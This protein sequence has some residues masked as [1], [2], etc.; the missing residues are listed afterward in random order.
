MHKLECLVCDKQ[1]ESKWQRTKTCSLECHRTRIRKIEGRF[2][3]EYIPNGSVGALAELVVS[4]DLL[5]K[6][7]SVFRALSPSCFCDLIAVKGNKSLKIEVR[8]GYLHSITKRLN[9]PTK[10][11]EQTDC[12][13]VFERNSKEIFY[14]TKDKNE[15]KL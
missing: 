5:S 8:T 9:F 12:F 14:L 10:T 7:F 4:A 15:F 1:F 3:D 2:A 13:A 11:N 6:G